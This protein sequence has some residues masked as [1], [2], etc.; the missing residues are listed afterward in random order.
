MNYAPTWREIAGRQNDGN[1]TSECRCLHVRSDCAGSAL[2]P[3]LVPLIGGFYLITTRMCRRRRVF[4]TNYNAW[5]LP[6]AG[7]TRGVGDA[8]NDPGKKRRLATFAFNFPSVSPS[9]THTVSG[10]PSDDKLHARTSFPRRG[11]VTSAKTAMPA[12]RG[13][14]VVCSTCRTNGKTHTGPVYAPRGQYETRSTGC[15]KNVMIE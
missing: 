11:W 14:R 13:C 3:P 4:T 15:H 9:K 7:S 2:S 12:Q 8:G 1:E 6:V 10:V 5:W